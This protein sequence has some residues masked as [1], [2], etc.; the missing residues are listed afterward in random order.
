VDELA[1]EGAKG[2]CC[3]FDVLLRREVDA[4]FSWSTIGTEE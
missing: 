3:S 4:T 2:R 1:R